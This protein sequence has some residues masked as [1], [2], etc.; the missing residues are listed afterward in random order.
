VLRVIGIASIT[1]PVDETPGRRVGE[2]VV[3]TKIKPIWF[4]LAWDMIGAVA[5]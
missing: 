5:H 4:M 2:S 1:K 3:L